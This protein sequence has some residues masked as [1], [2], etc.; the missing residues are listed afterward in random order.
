MYCSNKY[1]CTHS[2][3]QT[4]FIWGRAKN[5]STT[6]SISVKSFGTSGVLDSISS[7][8]PNLN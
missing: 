4:S 2:K 8:K 5:V 1:V 6:S 3:S 7:Y